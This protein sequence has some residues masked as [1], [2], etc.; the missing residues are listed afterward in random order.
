MSVPVSGLI[1]IPLTLAVF[2]FSSYLVEWAIFIAVLQ[3]AALI[4]VG[5]GFAVGLSPY[6]FATAFI[7]ARLIPQW[8]TGRMRFFADEPIAR[9][10]R[11]LAV[12]A[13]WC[14]VSAFVLPILFN[15]LPVDSARAGVDRGYY[16]Q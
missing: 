15:G 5:G 3:A 11:P 12:F 10:V 6:F 4:N 7:A 2:C 14:V 16:L 9:L 1:L 13:L 8:I